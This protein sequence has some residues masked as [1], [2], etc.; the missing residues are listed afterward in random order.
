MSLLAD[1]IADTTPPPVEAAHPLRQIA[2]AAVIGLAFAI[3]VFLALAVVAADPSGAHDE[4]AG[5]R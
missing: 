3:G 2:G 4:I 5:E 1:H